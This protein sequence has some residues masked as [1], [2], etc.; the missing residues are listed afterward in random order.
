MTTAATGSERGD[1]V[2][3]QVARFA[4]LR[5]RY[6]RL[7]AVLRE[8]LAHASARYAPLAIVQTRA[9]AI[10]SF[11]EKVQ[12]K[13]AKYQAGFDAIS[14]ITDLC[15]GRMITT[16]RSE[17]EHVC[18]FIEANFEV[19]RENSV[20]TSQRL[21]PT[22]F[23]YRSVHYIISLRRGVFPSREIPVEIPEELYPGPAAP[24][25]AEIQVRTMLEHA[26]SDLSHDLSYKSAFEIPMVWQREIAR[27]AAL[28]EDV[29]GAFERV[30]EG[31]RCYAASYGGYLSP[32][33]LAREIWSLRTVLEYDPGN[34][35]VAH[36]L[37]NLAMVGDDWQQ[38]IAVMSRY[39][40]SEHPP[41]L[42][43]LG[44]AL[45]KQHRDAPASAEF[46]EGRRC[47]ERAVELAPTDA[48]ALAS[49][50]G[51]WKGLDDERAR[52]LYRQAY[53]ADP[54]NPYPLGNYLER[55]I[56]HQRSTEIVTAMAPTIR[57]ALQRCA[58][59]VAVGMNM[60]WA[61]YDAGKLHLLLGDPYEAL[62]AYARAVRVSVG[63]A[64]LESALQSVAL[65]QGAAGEALPALE[66]V[67]RFLLAARVARRVAGAGSDAGEEERRR[68]A[69]QELAAVPGLVSRDVAPISPPVVILAG[70]TAA[71]VSESLESYRGLL[72]EAF[73]DFRGTV[74]SG[75][76][77]AGIC[78]LA[79]ELAARGD[80]SLRAVGYLPRGPLPPDAEVDRRYTEIRYTDGEG[81]TPLEPLQNWL[82][83]IASGVAPA[84]V[85]VLGINGGRI[86]GVEYRLALAL[87]ARV[88]VLTESGRAADNLLADRE[89]SGLPA[90]IPCPADPM[91]VRAFIGPPAAPFTA[92]SR[93][94]L[95]RA[96]HEEY[97]QSRLADLHRELADWGSLSEGLRE[98]NAQ[99]ADDSFDKLRAIGCEVVEVKGREVALMTFSEAEIET[100]A[101]MEHGRWN[102]ERLLA[103]WRWGPV[104]D[105]A[106]KISPHLVR[107]CDLGDDVK[108]WDRDAVRA[109]PRILARVG[110][111]VRRMR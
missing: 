62:E 90:L 69:L 48:D 60:P 87:G 81:F 97:R 56:A 107:W 66:W 89:W 43:D 79:G 10:G 106:G 63:G 65:L 41:L 24:M 25:K 13:A 75:G 14:Q 20:D 45:C 99:Q 37:G 35:E 98:S 111:E 51:T 94:E 30:R 85:R 12:R 74:I 21:R 67:R 6:E 52:D 55:E 61:H 54:S 38:A 50:A 76:T 64:A 93:E 1:W 22:E 102:A 31:L 17:V 108:R 46:L 110:L 95:A 8:V 9:K 78:G 26:W 105:V 34:V 82:D 15:G 59:Q 92:G 100:M 5:P 40:A 57:A 33:E 77:T 32:A 73:R 36:R 70:G 88:A 3:E 49:L 104:K 29:D 80:G 28:L 58:E 53:E 39:A 4:R 42:R 96:I 16:S 109:I 68:V 72:L 71:A 83:L 44:V 84:Q 86:A 19:D 91:T 101:E 27:I 18:R 11:A 2:A 47:L 103:G 7:A 23:G